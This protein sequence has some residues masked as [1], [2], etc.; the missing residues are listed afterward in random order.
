[1]FLLFQ[2]LLKMGKIGIRIVVFVQLNGFF[3][4][5]RDGM[6][7]FTALIAM[8]EGRFSFLVIT[9]DQPVNRPACTPKDQS[10]ST[11]N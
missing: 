5:V 1:M 10:G 11:W 3:D 9:D 2:N 8:T 6:G 7:W 4:G